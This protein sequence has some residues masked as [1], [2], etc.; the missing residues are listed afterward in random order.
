MR[1]IAQ[2]EANAGWRGPYYD[3]LFPRVM[4][5]VGEPA[6]RHLEDAAARLPERGPLMEKALAAIGSGAKKVTKKKG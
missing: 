2:L 3:K 4:K 1:A 6:R 5:E